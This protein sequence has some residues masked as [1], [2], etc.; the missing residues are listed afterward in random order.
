MKRVLLLSLLML[1]ISTFQYAFSQ[2]R[3]VT[4]RVTSTED[5]SVLPGVNVTVKGASRG[6]TT[7]ADGRYSLDGVGNDATLVFSFIGLTSQEVVVGNRTVIDVQMQADVRQLSEV[8]V[9]AL[10]QEAERDKV[11][12]ATA[13]VKG[14]SVVQSGE[15]SL[16]NGLAG[17]APGLNI[18]RS[19]GDPGA[20]TFIQ[21]RGQST[22]TGD[23]QPLIVIDGVPIFNSNVN[24]DAAGANTPGTTG[25]GGVQ[26]QS[27]LNDINPD[28]IASVEVLKSASAAALWGSRAANGVIMITTKKGK[29]TNGKVNIAYRGSLSL[30]EVNKV[31]DLQTSFGQGTNGLFVRNQARSWG[32][33]IADRSGG[34]DTYDTSP[35]QPYVE[36]PDGTRRYLIANGTEANPHGGKNSRDVYDHG[37]DV[38]RTGY[39]VD[40]SLSLS[41]GNERSNFFVSY[42]NLTQEGPVLLN[43]DYKRNTARINASTALTNKLTA[44]FNGSFSNVR[45]NRIQQGSNTSGIFLGG[46]RTPP[47]YDNSQYIGTYVEADGFANRNRQVSF[48]NPIGAST[49]GNYFDNP[50]WTIRNNKS[51][52]VVNRFLG[53]VELAYDLLPWLNLRGNV[54]VDTYGDRRTDFLNA[55]SAASPGGSYTEQF[56]SETQWNTNLFARATR[57]FSEDFNGSLLVGFNYNNRQYNNVGATARVFIVPDAPPN[58]LNSDPSNREPFNVAQTV[59]TSAGFMELNAELYNQLFL[60]ATGRAEAASTFGP[61][62]QSLFFYPS[63]SAAWQ[64]SKLTGEDNLLSF[65]KLRASFGVVGRQPDPYLN[66]TQYVSANFTESWGGTLNGSQYGVGGYQRSSTA[67]NPLIR[68]ERKAE[69]EVGADLRFLQNR[70]SFGATAFYNKTT[71]AILAVDVAGS[72]GFQAQVQNAATLENKGLEFNLGADWVPTNQAFGW[73]TTFIWSAYRNKVLSMS[74]VQSVFLAGFSDGS[75]RAVEGYP[76]GVLWGTYYGRNEDGGLILDGNGFPVLAASEGV[77]GNPNPNYRMSVGNTFRYKGLS[78]YALFDFQIGGDMWNGTRGALV[79]YGV[80][81]ETAVETTVNAAEAATLVTNDGQTI[82]EKYQPS[83]DGSYT[84]RGRVQDFGG[85]PVALDQAWYTGNGGGF[86]VNGPFVEDGSWARL[87]EITLNYT[88]S[89]AGFRKLT[90]FSSVGFSVTGRNLFL[91]TNYKGIDPETN[92]TGATNGRGIDYFQNPNTRSLIFT[93]SLNY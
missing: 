57:R 92:L 5:N 80:A 83:A 91:W 29:N 11:G 26:Q 12:T 93:L 68:P 47:D 50:L 15:A 13:T 44:S 82:A 4:G 49:S 2:D 28:D 60:T 30:N 88:L 55:I 76:V 37:K 22:I 33:K 64:F 77:I 17:K 61:E 73:N 58:L 6:T 14:N 90:R 36:F 24:T 69:V 41:G 48:R 43:S 40:N 16:L 34:P 9:T 71:D 79:N 10:G 38:F 54:G 75:S 84:F 23:I 87:R 70:I 52:S 19:G 3:T 25:V 32:D 53:N 27:R 78:L 20:S 63:V 8:V 46:L 62:A 7:G 86:S 35:G 56:L 31:P 1:V 66:L 67:G 45:S 59:R 81:A 85:G 65:G 18:T 89:S 72:S 42:A 39:F 51:F 21:L 74:G